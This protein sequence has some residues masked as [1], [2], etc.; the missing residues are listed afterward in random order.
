MIT[1][2]QKKTNNALVVERLISKAAKMNQ[3]QCAMSP[4]HRQSL[5]MSVAGPGS[6]SHRALALHAL[7]DLPLA[8]VDSL[9]AAHLGQRQIRKGMEGQGPVRGAPRPRHGH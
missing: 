5:S 7:A 8:Q 1:T 9:E 2:L 4:T 6:S 3:L